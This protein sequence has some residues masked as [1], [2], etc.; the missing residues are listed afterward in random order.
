MTPLTDWI[1]LAD[2]FYMGGYGLYVW[3]SLGMCAAAM[4]AEVIALKLRRRALAQAPVLLDDSDAQ[5]HEAAR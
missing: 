4:G 2:F 1:D 5:A 3:G